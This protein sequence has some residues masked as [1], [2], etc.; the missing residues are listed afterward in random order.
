M[1]CGMCCC[2]LLSLPKGKKCMLDELREM[3][4]E[5]LEYT[6]RNCGC[7]QIVD[8]LREVSVEEVTFNDSRR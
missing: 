6:A 7:Y 5:E 8:E 3:G 4:D 1:P 2:E